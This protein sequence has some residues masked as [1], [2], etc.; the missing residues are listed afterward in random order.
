MEYRLYIIF[1]SVFVVNYPSMIR[2]SQVH[3]SLYLQRFYLYPD[4]I[5]YNHQH[6][7]PLD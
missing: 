1:G 3:E 7:H 4:T 5:E 2:A 6:S